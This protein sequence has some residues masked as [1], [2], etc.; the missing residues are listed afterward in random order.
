MK[1]KL[2]RNRNL[3]FAFTIVQ[4][5]INWPLS[6]LF[7]QMRMRFSGCSHYG[8]ASFVE[9]KFRVNL[10]TVSW[11]KIISL[12]SKRFRGVREQRKTEKRDFWWFALAKN[13]ARAKKR[14]EGEGSRSIFHAGKTPKIPFLCLSLLPTPRKR[15]LRRLR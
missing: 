13:G 10:W 7:W 9:D 3:S 8:E 14:K 5:L 4:L 1:Q 11:D 12:R 2:N 6:M 15:L